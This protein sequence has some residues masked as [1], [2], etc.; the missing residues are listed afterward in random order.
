[1]AKDIFDKFGI[2]GKR[3]AIILINSGS[4]N[5][6]KDIAQEIKQE[7][8]K[9]ISLDLSGTTNTSLKNLHVDL[10][11]RIGEAEKDNDFLI[12]KSDG[13]EFNFG[14]TDMDNVAKRLIDGT[15]SS[16]YSSITSKIYF[17]LNNNFEY[18]DKSN[19]DNISLVNYDGNKLCFQ[20]SDIHYV[21]SGNMIDGKY[22]YIASTQTISFKVKVKS[23]KAGILTFA[24]NPTL[25]DKNNYKNYLLY[26]KFNDKESKKFI[27][28]PS[29]TAKNEIKIISHGLY[30][31]INNGQ[32]DI[33]ENNNDETF[34]IVQGSKVTFGTN[35]TFSGS[36]AQ[37]ELNIDNN[38]YSLNKNEAKNYIKIY[39]VSKDS[40]ENISLEEVENKNISGTNNEFDISIN[41]IKKENYEAII[42]I[43]VVYQCRIKED[44]ASKQPLTNQI[45]FSDEVFKD[46]TVITPEQ[47]NDEP[48]LPDLF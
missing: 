17:D 14:Y 16:S 8:Y 33:Q 45:K 18:V 43:L 21:Y 26:N 4:V 25:S 29:F 10:G 42:E 23:D 6:S 13:G 28:T 1:M 19:S 39:K 36:S 11:G 7:G 35:F 30:N 15:M 37:F 32:V 5:Y 46:A 22:E 31:G 40:S 38:F 24:E 2:K 41:D 34:K 9:I 3:K 27:Y 20:I 44:V 48:S 47:S 12:S